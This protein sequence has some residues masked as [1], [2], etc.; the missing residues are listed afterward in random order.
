MFE[1]EVI[2]SPLFF[3]LLKKNVMVKLHVEISKKYSIGLPLPCNP[4]F[5]GGRTIDFT[6]LT[7]DEAEW[8]LQIGSPHLV[9]VADIV[10]DVVAADAPVKS[11]KK[12]E[13]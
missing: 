4:C 8:L 6:K 12:T 9:R 13:A 7:I 3:K 11:V 10:A 5:I 1:R 2:L